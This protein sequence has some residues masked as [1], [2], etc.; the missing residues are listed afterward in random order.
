MLEKLD[1]E[2]ESLFHLFNFPLCTLKTSGVY[3][4]SPTV[5]ILARRMWEQ[6]GQLRIYA[7]TMYM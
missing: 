7:Y 5:Q 1:E 6:G 2:A 4:S 3:N